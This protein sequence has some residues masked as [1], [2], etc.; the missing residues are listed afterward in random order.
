[1]KQHRNYL[2]RRKPEDCGLF[3]ALPGWNAESPEE[4][5]FSRI[6][7]T[8]KL[9]VCGSAKAGWLWKVRDAMTGQLLVQGAAM[10][11]ATAMQNAED[12]AK[13]GNDE[14]RVYL[15]CPE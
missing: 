6:I 14:M 9:N 3:V 13:F 8:R 2:K 15:A 4:T 11:I 10:H 7:N 5:A 1:M 12:T